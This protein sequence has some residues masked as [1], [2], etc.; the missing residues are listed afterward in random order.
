MSLRKQ[1][2]RGIAWVA[3]ER[4]GQ[5]LVQAATLILLARLLTPEDFGLIG[6]LL[7]FLAVGQSF[8]DSGMGQALIREKKINKADRSTV[9]WFN[10]VISAFF[11][12]ILYA[13]APW[14][15]EFYSQPELINLTRV[16]G[17]TIIF[18]AFSV[19][20]RAE[21]T[22]RLEFKKQ[23]VAQIP[24]VVIAGVLSVWMAYSEYGVWAIAAQSIVTTILSSLFIWVV[25]PV[26]LGF[27][28]DRDSFRR[29]FHFGNRLL[30]AGLLNTVFEHIYKLVIGKFFLA[31]T[32]GFYTQAQ[33]LQRLASK[34]LS[35]IIQKVT[36][37]LL[38]KA[39]LES[40]RLKAGYRK[41][42][43]I[44]SI[45]IFPAMLVLIILAEPIVVLLMGEKWVQAASFLQV[46]SVSG[47]LY[48]LNAINLNIL[49]V[50]GRSDL[51]LK[52]E[53][54]KKLIIIFAIVSG[55]YFG[56]WGLL[57]GQVFSAIGALFINTIYSSRLIG[58]SLA[59]QIVDVMKVFLV[60][61]PMLL[62]GV[63]LKLVCDTNNLVLL[64]V[65]LFLMSGVYLAS[66][67]AIKN[68]GTKLAIGLILNLL[69]KS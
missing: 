7:I 21:M 65:G 42:I 59:E 39:S 66:I 23:A 19:V 9:F 67:F 63:S 3:I 43:L 4:F 35:S 17:L 57:I 41:V 5:Q 61:V 55:F 15:A 16:M 1:A 25:N 18:S 14:I 60:A 27:I 53:L 10:L 62:V 46:L 47:M 37:P 56:I 29:F 32:L 12:G 48:H 52:L 6:M 58:Y 11:Y 31:S 64:L 38:A 20:Q 68:E 24:A 28:W 36:Y 51:F 30:A 8:V 13:A 69:K 22:Q 33:K 2:I 54:L 44:S 49:K 34:N 40:K 26:K 50:K 45:V